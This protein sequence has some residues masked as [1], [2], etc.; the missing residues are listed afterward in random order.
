MV[1]PSVVLAQY[2]RLET[3][4]VLSLGALCVSLA[5]NPGPVTH[6]RN[7]M[8]LCNLFIAFAAILT[9]LI[10]HNAWLIG[11]EIVA[12]CF[13]FSMFNLYGARASSIGTAALLVMILGI[14]QHL[15]PLGTLKGGGPPP[16]RLPCCRRP[17]YMLLSLSIYQILPYRLA[18]Q[19]LGD[20]INEVAEY[21]RLKG[22]FYDIDT[23]TDDT[24]SRTG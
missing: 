21:L 7:G 17:L 11:A 5:D 8:L 9:G 1:I 3:G 12:L 20:C 18:Q 22:R 24:L 13:V 4:T 10:N 23:N 19:A 15:T 16:Y 14:D 6:K 2:D